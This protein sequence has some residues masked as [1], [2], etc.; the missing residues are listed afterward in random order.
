MTANYTDDEGTA[1]SVTGSATGSV[2]D[3]TPPVITTPAP[4]TVTAEGLF[5]L[6]DIGVTTGL[7]IMQMVY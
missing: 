4:I 5:T 7:M 6:V 1:E 3:M 2:S